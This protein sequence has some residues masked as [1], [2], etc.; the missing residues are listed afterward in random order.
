MFTCSRDGQIHC[1][2]ANT[3]QVKWKASTH[4][5]NSRKPDWGFSGSAL[6][7]NNLVIFDIGPTVAFDKATG[8]VVWKSEDY[9]AGYGSPYNFK[10]GTYEWI[11]SFN[12][13]G[14][15]VMYPNNGKEITRFKWNTSYGV[16]AATPVVLQDKVFISS[17]YNTGAAL[18]QLKQGECQ[19]I[20][21]NRNMNNHMNSCVLY[22]GHLYGINGNS[23]K[24]NLTCLEFATGNVKWSQDGLGTGALMMA[25]GKL[26]VQGER[27]DVAIVEA[28]P[29]GYTEHGRVRGVL[30]GTC[31]V[32]PT[33][34]NGLL[35][36]R[37]NQGDLV[38]LDV[39][40]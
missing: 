5:F 32:V 30:S 13:Y 4:D 21:K 14:L 23:G 7:Y 34:A 3:G 2:D 15:V 9:K 24:G 8:R 29:N 40:K 36:C 17:G 1:L 16:N 12:R 11:A 35:Y 6:L 38:C 10:L 19:E 31:W 25:N 22:N 26:I 39:R 28:S 33:L 37:S 18:V 20:W 27:G